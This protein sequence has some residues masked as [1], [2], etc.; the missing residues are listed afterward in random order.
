MLLRTAIGVFGEGN[1]STH[2]IIGLGETEKEA[3]CLIQD[4]V[5]LGVLPALFAFTPVKGTAMAECSRPTL[6]KYRRVQLARY[7]IVNELARFEDMSFN[8]EGELVGFGLGKD[9][10]N[11]L[12]ETGFPFL[13]S[14]CQN[15]NRPFYNEKPGGPLFNYPR[16]LT[17]R[18]MAAIRQQLQLL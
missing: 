9:T 6:E 13:T 17:V 15:C 8:E 2:L 11:R 12:V 1:V 4:C 18:E 3:L 14:G 16:N 7:V 5:D 10:L